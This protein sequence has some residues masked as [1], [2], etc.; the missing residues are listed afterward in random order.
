MRTV[1]V[2]KGDTIIEVLFALTVFSL[3]A[4]GGLSL[5]NQGTAVA[6]RSLEITL[7]R[8]QIDS[9]ADALRYLNRAYIN[10]Y[11]AGGA[12]T[13]RWNKVIVANAVSQAQSFDSI[14]DN[15]V[16][17]L[18]T[19]SNN[20]FALDVTKLDTDEYLHPTTDVATYAQV[21]YDL[22]V[23]TAQGIWVQAVR[24]PTTTNSSGQIQ[25]GF[26]DFHINACWM[27]PGQSAPVTIGTIVRLYEPRS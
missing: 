21:R 13:D 4:V 1:R 26:Y 20:P 2:D 24:S 17:N 5:M 7:V 10:D 12:A 23:T 18:P 27:S 3:V 6:Q 8:E 22:P 14:A 19:S 25:T 16:C 9:Q 15:G 11:G